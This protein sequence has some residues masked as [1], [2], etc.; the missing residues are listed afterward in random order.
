MLRKISI[1][2]YLFINRKSTAVFQQSFIVSYTFWF[3]T[4]YPVTNQMSGVSV[5]KILAAQNLT[6]KYPPD[7]NSQLTIQL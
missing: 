7:N 2:S 3:H 5:R 1:T 4:L 6:H